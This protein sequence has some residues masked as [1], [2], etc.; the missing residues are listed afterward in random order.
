MPRDLK[1]LLEDTPLP[2]HT[3]AMARVR[4]NAMI[5]AMALAMVKAMAL[6]MPTV[7]AI[8]MAFQPTQ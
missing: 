8:S 6:A 3:H 7:K 2:P 1:Q 4:A 5:M